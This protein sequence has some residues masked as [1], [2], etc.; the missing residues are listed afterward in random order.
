MRGQWVGEGRS[1]PTGARRVKSGAVE[2]RPGQN[3]RGRD[4]ILHGEIDADAADR[5]HRVRGIADARQAGHVPA[6]E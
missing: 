3:A 1:A 2:Q 5:R 4:G 6:L